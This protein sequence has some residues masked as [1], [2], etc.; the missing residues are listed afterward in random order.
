MIGVDV[1]KAT[2]LSTTTKVKL[3]GADI[4]VPSNARQIRA[5]RPITV[6]VTPT[7][8]QSVISQVVLESDD[9]PLQP[10]IFAASPIQPLLGATGGLSMPPP[11]IYFLNQ[12]CN[13]GERISVYGQALKTNT[14]EPFMECEVY[15]DTDKPALPA[16]HGKVGTLTQT[17][18]TAVEAFDTTPMG[19]NG[20][21][22]LEFA[23]GIVGQRTVVASEPYV[24]RG[25]IVSSDLSPPFPSTF[26]IAPVSP[27]LS[28]AGV[29]ESPG[30]LFADV[31]LALKQNATLTLSHVLDRA[32]ATTADFAIGV[33]YS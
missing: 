10:S 28:T 23:Y 12:A 14:V 32:L 22:I 8:A 24:G 30:I 15:Y 26:A 18:T 29:A 5:I 27:V 1:V 3:S 16:L 25:K 6:P 17:G 2:A 21:T 33:I 13:G 19:I 7:A 20:G 11:P 31:G 9:L 4:V